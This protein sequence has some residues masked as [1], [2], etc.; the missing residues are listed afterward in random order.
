MP[1]LF[2]SWMGT[3]EKTS[4][5]LIKV[6]RLKNYECLRCRTWTKTA[7]NLSSY[8][9]YL[10]NRNFS[11]VWLSPCQ[12]NIALTEHPPQY[13]QHN[14]FIHTNTSP[15]TRPTALST[16][17]L[18]LVLIP[19]G[20]RSQGLSRM[21]WEPGLLPD[22]QAFL[23]PASLA[24]PASLILLTHSHVLLWHPGWRLLLQFLPVIC[25]RNLQLSSWQLQRERSKMNLLKH[26]DSLQQ[27][28]SESQLRPSLLR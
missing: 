27:H 21:Q 4:R 12:P 7:V 22:N 28:Q 13:M 26:R 3:L 5:R 2:E 24:L 19:P 9:G 11:V 10:R 1:N 18:R 16:W 23:A 6:A 17:H 25:P 14:R 20:R 8:S 15:H